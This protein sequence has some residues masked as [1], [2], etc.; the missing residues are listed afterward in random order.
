MIILD[1]MTEFSLDETVETRTESK[2]V[3]AFAQERTAKPQAA[4]KED[5]D[6][7][8]WLNVS[9]ME[10]EDV[11]ELLET[12]SFYAGETPVFFVK[13]GKKMACSQKVSPNRALMAELSSFLSENC[14]K[15]V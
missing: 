10:D 1:R 2:P 12:L 14:I 4:E 11:E 7:V 8:L 6:K 13:D 15:L 9:G 5:K 3:K